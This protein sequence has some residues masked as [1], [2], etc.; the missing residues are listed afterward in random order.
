[1]VVYL[2]K[3][4]TLKCGSVVAYEYVFPVLLDPQVTIGSLVTTGLVSTVTRILKRHRMQISL[5][6]S[7][8]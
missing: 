5:Y 2:N 4:V 6:L 7:F 3:T 1:M 8:G